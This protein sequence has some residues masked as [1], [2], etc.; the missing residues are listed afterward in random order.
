MIRSLI[1]FWVNHIHP[2]ISSLITTIGIVG[3]VISL[4]ILFI[5]T[6]LAHE[7]LEKDA[8]DFDESILLSIHSV[9][10]PYLDRVMLTVTHLANPTAVLVVFGVSSLLLLWQR[11]YIELV[12]LAIASFGAYILN[13][14]LKLLFVKVRPQLWTQLITETSFSFPSG[15]ALGSIVLYGFIAYLLAKEY[16]KFAA[17]I[18]TVAT[19]LIAAIGLSRLYLG[20]HWPTDII[21][22][23]GVGFLWL[24]SCITMLKLRRVEQGSE[25]V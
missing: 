5:L 16:S 10:N 24:I 20:V 17:L 6:E 7:V 9:A 4:S 1:S 14:E 21:A 2:K 3:L 23:Y 19:T 25:T 12:M 13:T 22:G 15:H 8:F 11:Y 18:Y